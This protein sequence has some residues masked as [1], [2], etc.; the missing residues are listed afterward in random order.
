MKILLNGTE[1]EEL[2]ITGPIE[3]FRGKF[4]FLCIKGRTRDGYQVH[5]EAKVTAIRR[6]RRECGFIFN[7]HSWVYHGHS[8]TGI[9]TSMYPFVGAKYR[10]CTKCETKQ[11]LDERVSSTQN[12]TPEMSA[13]G[14]SR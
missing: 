10:I 12:K 6:E 1:V 3:G 5:I 4:A 8:P 11:N 9:R 7:R 13:L 14:S 2:A